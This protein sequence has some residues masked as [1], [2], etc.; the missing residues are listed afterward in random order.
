MECAAAAFNLYRYAD[1]LCLNPYSNG[2]RGGTRSTSTTT[3]L[4]GL[5]P[6]SNGMRGGPHKSISI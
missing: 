3:I 4:Y 6:Y 2:M 5:N 1:N